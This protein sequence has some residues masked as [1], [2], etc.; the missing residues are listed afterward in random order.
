VKT[1]C[2]SLILIVVGMTQSGPKVSSF[3]LRKSA[4]NCIRNCW[5]FAF[6]FFPLFLFLLRVFHIYRSPPACPGLFF[7]AFAVLTEL[8]CIQSD[9]PERRPSASSQLPG[10][11]SW[12][13]PCGWMGDWAERRTSYLRHMSPVK[14]RFPY[15]YTTDTPE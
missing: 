4:T 9:V 2:F 11:G 3:A 15:L 6:E 10:S 13:S 14:L 5:Q 1:S 8:R 7:V 12:I